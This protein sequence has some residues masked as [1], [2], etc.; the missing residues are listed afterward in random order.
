VAATGGTLFASSAG[1]ATVSSI[2]DT[3]G[4]LTLLGQAGTDA[5]TVD[6]AATP[7]GRYLYVQGGGTGIVDE[8]AVGASGALTELGSITVPNAAG[9]EGI[10]AS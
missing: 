7:D 1:S 6:S 9:G 10:V 4:A 8:F 3:G 5:G 2:A